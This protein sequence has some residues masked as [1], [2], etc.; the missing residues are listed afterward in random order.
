MRSRL[1]RSLA[2]V[3]A[4]VAMAGLPACGGPATAPADGS[5]TISL[6]LQQF[7]GALPYISDVIAREE[8]IFAR[9]GLDVEFVNPGDGATAMRL[10]ANGDT[11]GL[12]ADVASGISAA[13]KGQPIAVAGS[14][15]NKSLFQISARGD[16]LGV[17]GD[18]K[19]KVQALRGKTVGV[20]GIGSSADHVM[21]GLLREAG[22]TP[23][24]DV[25]LISVTTGQAAIAQFQQK[26]LDA[27]INVA[28]AAHLIEKA[29]AG[30]LY[31][32]IANEAPPRFAD[33][34]IG[35][36]TNRSFAKQNPEA[37]RRWIAA[38]EQAIRFIGEPAN[39]KKVVGYIAENITS[40]DIPLAEKLVDY[41]NG[42]AYS[43]TRPRLAVP[44]RVLDAQIKLLGD[45]GIPAGSLNAAEFVVTPNR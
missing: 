29:G 35:M 45:G 2:V 32:D 1:A 17:R 6:T 27:F 12:L 25:T 4:A 33:S 26:A 28:P 43:A 31:V 18:W 15:I 16:L 37:L 20:P 44:A 11:Q 5:D 13:A 14:V 41:L 42:T 30:G 39:R 34:V 10:L 40:D 19:A 38:E 22:L 24:T 9:N 23:G 8:G 21:R 36:M 7:P 3:T